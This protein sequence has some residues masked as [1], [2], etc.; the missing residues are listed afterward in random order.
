M[1]GQIIYNVYFYW[2][3]F[4][5]DFKYMCF[6]WF[7]YYIYITRGYCHRS[8]GSTLLEFRQKFPLAQLAK[9][10]QKFELGVNCQLKQK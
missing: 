5:T 6:D 1:I 7:K 3:I 9:G 8:P 2:L 4:K 10:W